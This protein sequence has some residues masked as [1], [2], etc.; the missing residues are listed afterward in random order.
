MT[1]L[2]CMLSLTCLHCINFLRINRDRWIMTL[3]CRILLRCHLSSLATQCCWHYENIYIH[4]ALL[5]LI[6]ILLSLQS[7]GF[8]D[9]FARQDRD[10]ARTATT[11][12]F[13]CQKMY[14]IDNTILIWWQLPVRRWPARLYVSYHIILDII[15]YKQ[16]KKKEKKRNTRLHYRKKNTMSK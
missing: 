12:V 4:R 1:F 7:Y 11:T 6:I 13:I 3:R 16:N 15:Q 9:F 2:S 10:F 8:S 14:T 5:A